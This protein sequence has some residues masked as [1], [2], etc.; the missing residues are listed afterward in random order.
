[1]I[2]IVKQLLLGTLLILGLFLFAC[3]PIAVLCLCLWAASSNWVMFF[4]A[5]FLLLVVFI[6]PGVNGAHRKRNWG[7]G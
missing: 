4:L 3:I 5:T 7:L 6:A 1:M 2:P